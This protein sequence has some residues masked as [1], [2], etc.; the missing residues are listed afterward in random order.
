MAQVL[1]KGYGYYDITA[2]PYGG[3]FRRVAEDTPV[4][5]IEGKRGQHPDEVQARMGDRTIVVRRAYIR[6]VEGS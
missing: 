4:E 6:D 5:I 3:C 1:L 2:Y